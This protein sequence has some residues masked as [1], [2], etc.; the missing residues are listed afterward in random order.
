VFDESGKRWDAVLVP[1]DHGGA[2]GSVGAFVLGFDG[3]VGVGIWAI[4]MGKRGMNWDGSSHSTSGL[5]KVVGFEL[6]G[7]GLMDGV[8]DERLGVW[9]S[10]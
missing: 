1:R 10:C 3:G 8:N 2:L 5:G 6:G 7:N 9:L 4:G